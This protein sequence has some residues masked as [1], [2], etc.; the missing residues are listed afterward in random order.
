MW[1]LI[2]FFVICISS[3]DDEAFCDERVCCD[4]SKVFCFFLFFLVLVMCILILLY[5]HETYDII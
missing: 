1:F 3:L 5:F 2:R 4:S